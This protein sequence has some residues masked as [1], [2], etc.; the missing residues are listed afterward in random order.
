MPCRNVSD[1]SR[2]DFG[3]TLTCSEMSLSRYARPA[4]G[5]LPPSL[6]SAYGASR[7][8]FAEPE[9]NGLGVTTSRPGWSRSSQVLMF[10][11]LPLRVT[12]VTTEPNGDA[13]V[14]AG[15]PVVGDEARVDELRDVGL[16]G[17]VHDVG[18]E[19]GRDLARLVARRAVGLAERHA[20][21]GGVF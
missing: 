14:L 1:A 9:L 6:F 2:P 19:P 10:F 20:L 16:D 17:E 18:R 8:H 15:V 21:A 4:F 13:L 5:S 11:G 7:F 3:C 12:I